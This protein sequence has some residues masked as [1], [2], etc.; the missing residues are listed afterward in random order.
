VTAVAAT[1][2]NRNSAVGPQ[3]PPTTTA[4]R[5]ARTPQLTG[6][7]R[8]MLLIQPG[9]NAV[10][11]R[12]DDR[13]ISGRP[14]KFAVAIIDASRRSRSATPFEKPANTIAS[15]AD[16]TSTTS[17]PSTPPCTRTPRASAT[18]SRIRAWRIAVMPARATCESTIARRDAGAARKR[19]TTWRS[20]SLIIAIPDHVPPKKAF[21]HTT[22]GVRNSM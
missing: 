13:N 21:M 15:S 19:S 2:K 20:R 6:L 3:S 8:E 4:F 22:P 5:A 10:E 12:I 9:I 7:K 11:S 1:R 17:Q 16:A 14:T 18:S